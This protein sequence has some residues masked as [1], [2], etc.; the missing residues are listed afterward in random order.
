MPATALLLV[1]AAATLHAGWNLLLAGARDAEAA[2]AVMIITSFTVYAPVAALTWDVELAAAPY[3]AGSAALQ[4][5]Y[6]SLLAA[7]YARSELSLVYPIA[8]GLAPVLTLAAAAVALAV[9]PSA[10]QAL[11]VVSIGAGVLLVRGL[12]RGADGRG[13]LLGCAIA[14][15]IAGYTLVDKAGLRHAEP[16][17]YFELVLVGSLLYPADVA[18]R[19]G[20]GA[21]RAA[22]GA[23]TLASGVAGFATYA[24]VLAAL[25]RAPAASVAAVRETSV[26][27]AT[28]LAALV[29]HETVGVRRLA[30]AAIVAAGTVLIALS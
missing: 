24:L 10:L 14:A 27:L 17:S 26:V 20:V 5:A 28:G 15:C 9:R 11:G 16:I 1:L 21:L 25:E 3:I 4:L 22:V 19:K 6:F 2:V 30:G 13:V 29:L 7:A 18:R 23:R 12:G 8:R